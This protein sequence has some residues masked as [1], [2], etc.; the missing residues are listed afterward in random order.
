LVG[1][2]QVCNSSGSVEVVENFS[3]E[4]IINLDCALKRAS[5][6]ELLYHWV[7]YKLGFVREK[8]QVLDRGERLSE[9]NFVVCT[10]VKD[11]D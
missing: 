7:D 10:V 3:L 1:G 6:V 8:P 11:R 5:V 9:Q 2:G 4:G